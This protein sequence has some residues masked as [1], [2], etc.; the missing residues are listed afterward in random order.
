MHWDANGDVVPAKTGIVPLSLPEGVDFNSGTSE[1]RVQFNGSLGIVYNIRS[2]ALL[3]VM[4]AS[5]VQHAFV[6]GFNVAKVCT[7]TMI[8]GKALAVSLYVMLAK[9]SRTYA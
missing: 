1:F 3:L 5:G 2:R 6:Q 9:V 8:C 4:L 7:V